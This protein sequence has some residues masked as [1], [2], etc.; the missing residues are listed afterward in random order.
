MSDDLSLIRQYVRTRAPETLSTVVRRH[1]DL[2]YSAC[3]RIHGDRHAAEDS[4]QDCFLRLIEQAGHIE[5]SL[6]GWL[7]RCATGV[8]LNAVRSGKARSNRE[9]TYV[10]MVADR[11]QRVAWERVA[12][13]IDAALDELP[14]ELRHVVVEH[15][16][17]QRPQAELAEELSVSP[18]TVSRRVTKGVDQLRRK[19]G[20]AGVA[21]PGVTLAAL[22]AGNAVSAAPAS[23]TATL[24]KMAV[25]GI[26]TVGAQTGS[27]LLTTA[28]GKITALLAVGVVAAS[29]VVI[30]RTMAQSG[31]K[32]SPRPVAVR[33]QEPRPS[34]PPA[35]PPSEPGAT[36]AGDQAITLDQELQIALN[37]ISTQ[38]AALRSRPVHF[39][40]MKL[41]TDKHIDVKNPLGD[42]STGYVDSISDLVLDGDKHHEW[43]HV[44]SSNT[45]NPVPVES[46]G[47]TAYDADWYR[48]YTPPWMDAE[49]R[50]RG[51]TG[52][53][54]SLAN[55]LL[56][57][58]EMAY[59][60]TRGDFA[61]YIRAHASAM[62]VGHVTDEKGE[63]LLSLE[64]QVFTRAPVGGRIVEDQSFQRILL[65]PEA[66]YQPRQFLVRRDA[67]RPNASDTGPK[68]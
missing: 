49:G 19:L 24:G 9:R 5:S 61:G 16:L 3:L 35:Q 33:A 17:R 15:F 34:K 41:K 56:D 66:Q 31:P 40:Y 65:D 1:Q 45:R 32:P 28:A 25:A 51:G 59:P 26:G 63:D 54:H 20:K 47:E 13:L 38:E 64:F 18:A 27:G 12:P 39:T 11:D 43:T 37:M 14:D 62:T 50:A 52:V 29:S 67:T 68:A 10:E 7:H 30:H 48:M 60:G 6:G 42:G 44:L 2:V 22:L 57:Y 4:A 53:V 8:S 55:P 21:M 46:A 58:L 36:V 23:L